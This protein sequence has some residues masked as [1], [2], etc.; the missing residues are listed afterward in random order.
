M[1][2]LLTLG[3]AIVAVT[4]VCSVFEATLYST[5]LGFLQ[6]RRGST[7]HA[8]A[9]E[10]FIEMKMNIEVSKQHLALVVD[11]SNMERR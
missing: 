5:Q 2:M 4:I 7:R 1:P 8:R 6:A 3:L 10:P 11:E 9:A